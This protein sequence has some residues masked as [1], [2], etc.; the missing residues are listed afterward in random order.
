MPKSSNHSSLNFG[1]PCV[2]MKESTVALLFAG[3]APKYTVGGN[4]F[5]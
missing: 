1:G 4:D 2:N 3:Y 5:G